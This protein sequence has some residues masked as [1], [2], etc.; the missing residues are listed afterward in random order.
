MLLLSRAYRK[1]HRW[2][3]AKRVAIL[4]ADALPES[5]P[6]QLLA[7]EMLIAHREFEDGLARL[8]RLLK[9]NPNDVD[10]LVWYGLGRARLPSIDAVLVALDE[11]WRAGRPTEAILP[12][13]RLAPNRSA[14]REA[15]ERIRYALQAGRTEDGPLA[16]ASLLCVTGR[17]D[18]G[19][20]ILQSVL[21]AVPK[22]ALILR[23]LGSY[24]ASRGLDAQAEEYLKRSA[25]TGDSNSLL[26]L[27]NYLRSKGRDR[28]ALDLVNQVAAHDTTGDGLLR[29]VEIE[30]RLGL[31]D[32]A[33]AHLDTLLTRL[34]DH[35]EAR[36]F[37]AQLLLGRGQA[38]EAAALARAV[39]TV[40]PWIPHAHATAGRALWKTGDLTGAFDELVKAWRRDDTDPVLAAEIAALAA[41]LGKKDIAVEFASRRVALD[42]GN[43]SALLILAGAYV[44]AGHVAEAEKTLATVPADAM[45]S[46]DALIVSGDVHAARGRL[47]A[48]RTAYTKALQLAPES[49]AALTGLLNVDAEP[50]QLQKIRPVIDQAAARHPNDPAYL[51]LAARAAAASGDAPAAEARLRTALAGNPANADAS[52]ELARLLL[53]TRRPDEARG[54]L[55]AAIRVAPSSAALN[56]ELAGVLDKLGLLD[57]AKKRYE[58]VRRLDATAYLASARLASVIVRQNGNLDVALQHASA[59]K[60]GLASDPEVDDTL[61]WI[62][63]LKRR[64]SAALPHLE[65]AVKAQPNNALFRYHLGAGY[66]QLGQIQEARRE[67]QRALQLDQG[68]VGAADA[69]KL[70]AAIGG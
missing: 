42:R 6:A 9:Q 20:T 49:L 37:K 64:A 61:G 69:K 30:M 67:L 7:A 41:Y 56:F 35:P 23:F 33:A 25:D 8:T 3:D 34:P 19:V 36:I 70:L 24:A 27:A 21:K 32:Q 63:V 48:A 11:G 57:E 39:T 47:E 53:N 38:A 52:I 43:P 26:S 28:E 17:F 44:R 15:E 22:H 1:A 10:A 46:A 54:T 50:A 18:E 45:T 68:F 13:I 12:H 62:L 65:A 55:E 59:A 40:T 58:D 4:A 5:R 60:Q 2:Q 16:L 29:A 14:D 51:I 66:D 31:L